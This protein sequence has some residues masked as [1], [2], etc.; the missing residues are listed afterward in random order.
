[1]MRYIRAK[2]AWLENNSK[3]QEPNFTDYERRSRVVGIAPAA[4]GRRQVRG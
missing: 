1:M 2:L 4:R 3:G